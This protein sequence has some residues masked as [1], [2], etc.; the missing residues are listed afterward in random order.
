MH[1]TNGFHVTHGN[2]SWGDSPSVDKLQGAQQ[3]RVS[4]CCCDAP[5]MAPKWIFHM[6]PSP[7]LPKK[8]GVTCFTMLRLWAHT[9]PACVHS[10]IISL[11]T[12][13]H[14]ASMG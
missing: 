3:Q 6:G 11:E 14:K 8:F 2:C 13:L 1:Q 10:L 12:N 5:W 9:G 7:L 4:E